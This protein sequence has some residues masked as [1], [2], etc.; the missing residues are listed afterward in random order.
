[1]YGSHEDEMH[2]TCFKL[3]GIQATFSILTEEGTMSKDTFSIQ[4]ENGP[5]GEYVNRLNPCKLNDFLQTIRLY[6]APIEEWPM[7]IWD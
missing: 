5:P 6:K 7:P 2:G 1:L 3:E 4:I